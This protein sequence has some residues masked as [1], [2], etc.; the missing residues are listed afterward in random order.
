MAT[1]TNQ[2]DC[3]WVIG[4]QESFRLPTF[5]IEAEPER[6]WDKDCFVKKNMK[7]EKLL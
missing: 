6:S 1:R 7:N 5:E 4:A 3:H 2:E